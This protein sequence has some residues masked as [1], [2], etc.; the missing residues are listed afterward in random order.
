MKKLTF[1]EKLNTLVEMHVKKIIIQTKNSSMEDLP[2]F[3]YVDSRTVG[4]IIEQLLI[5]DIRQWHLEDLA[6]R[7]KS[8]DIEYGDMKKRIEYCF[9]EKRPKLIVALNMMLQKTVSRQEISNDR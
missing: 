6:C 8:N 3:E 2:D 9:K 4:E 1:A 7:N 5:L